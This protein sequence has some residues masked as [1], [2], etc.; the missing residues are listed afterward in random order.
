MRYSRGYVR[1]QR[2]RWIG[3]YYLKGKRTS[4]SLGL[5]KDLTKG[6]AKEK[7]AELVKESRRAGEVTFLGPFVEGPYFSFYGRKWK[8]S[9]RDKNIIRVRAHLVRAFS[10][11]ELASFKRDELQDFLDS[12]ARFS[13][14]LVNKL[15]FDLKQIFDMAI[16]EGLLK[17][18][19]ALLLFSPKGAKRPDRKVMGSKEI[20]ALLQVLESR[21]RLVAKLCIFAGLRPGE[22]FALRWGSIADTFISVRERVYEGVLD[23]PKSERGT[24][25]GALAKVLIADIAAWKTVA[26]DTGETAFVFRSERGTPLSSHN[27]WQRNM[28][29]KLKEVGLEW[30]TFQVMRRTFVSL[31]KATGG[32]PKAIADQCGHDIGVSVN[33]YTQ[34]TLDSK[35][36]LVNRLERSLIE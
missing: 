20:S 27:I 4:K 34:S 31:C 36:E 24:R 23:S 6:D 1:K 8:H 35:L 30:C 22:V 21:E 33:V 14:S 25:Q 29:P 5:V 9:T 11:R 7:L 16:A 13:Y 12:K 3:A 32:D 15:R 18:N 28:Q 17:L 26:V 19:P 10:N 2:G